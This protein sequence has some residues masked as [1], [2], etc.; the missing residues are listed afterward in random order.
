MHTDAVGRTYTVLESSATNTRESLAEWL[1]PVSYI[2]TGGVPIAYS[3]L[4][5]R[6]GLPG[7]FE[8]SSTEK[9]E[10]GFD[11]EPSTLKKGTLKLFESVTW[12]GDFSL[13]PHRPD[14]RAPVTSSAP[15]ATGTEDAEPESPPVVLGDDCGT[16]EA[17]AM[18]AEGATVYCARREYTDAYV[19]YTSPG[20]APNPTYTPAPTTDTVP[21]G[22]DYGSEAHIETCMGKTGQTYDQCKEQIEG[23]RPN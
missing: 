17:T 21:P 7:V 5:L 23:S 9:L 20:V 11:M 13:L 12:F 19:W 22:S 8:A 6:E 18:T 10:W 4:G 14:T 2:P 15:A 3:A 1:P 16:P